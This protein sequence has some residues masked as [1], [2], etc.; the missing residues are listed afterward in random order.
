MSLLVLEGGYFVQEK[1]SRARGSSDLT[2][3]LFYFF[4]VTD[5]IKLKVVQ[6][7]DLKNLFQR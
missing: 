1:V 3:C 6:L 4:K 5:K 7:N 2:A